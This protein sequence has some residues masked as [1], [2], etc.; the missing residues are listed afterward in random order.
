MRVTCHYHS[1][2]AAKFHGSD[3][4][5]W[6]APAAPSAQIRYVQAPLAND[7]SSPLYLS[8]SV[9]DALLRAAVSSQ[10]DWW[11]MINPQ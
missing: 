10:D 6:L 11:I 5:E 9:A 8:G 4:H 7:S 3:R 2:C 1:A